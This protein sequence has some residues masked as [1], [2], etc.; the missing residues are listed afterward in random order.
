VIGPVPTKERAFRLINNERID[1]CALDLNLH[2]TPATEIAAALSARN[3][4]FV[5][6]SGYSDSEFKEPQVAP[7]AVDTE[8]H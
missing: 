6:V 4:P 2:G 1:V 7:T 5:L 3:I 8:Y